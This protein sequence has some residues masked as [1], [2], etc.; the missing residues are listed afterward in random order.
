[1]SD[2]RRVLTVGGAPSIG[3]VEI[4]DEFTDSFTLITVPDAVRDF[5]QLYPGLHL[6]PGGEAFYTR[7]GF[8]AAGPGPGSRTI[9]CRP[10]PTS[11]TPHHPPASGRA[12]KP[13]GVLRPGAR[14]VRAAARSLALGISV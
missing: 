9:R 5:P 14:E 13:D 4:Y 2:E 12:D 1:M 3:T 7:T 11:T 6:L 8:G 10:T